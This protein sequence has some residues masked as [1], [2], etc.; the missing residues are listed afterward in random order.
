MIDCCMTRCHTSPIARPAA[1]LALACV[2]AAAGCSPDA[3]SSDRRVIPDDVETQLD[4]QFVR[5]PFKDQAAAAVLRER[6]LHD[7]DF[8]AG[9]TRLTSGGKSR[10]EILTRALRA[11]GGDITVA[12]GAAD[13]KLHQ[14]RIAEV[15]RQLEAA[16]IAPD[17]F[18]VTAQ[19]AGEAAYTA[20]AI[21]I[22]RVIKSKP[23][24]DTRGEILDP[25][26]GASTPSNGGNP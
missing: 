8:Q 17:R 3:P 15:S 18:E 16:G 21:R 19:S 2:L 24:P 6:I 4:R 25:R 26:G 9:S 5:D 23:L 14:A 22:R 20:D 13:P 12:R 11:D 1:A 7:S 10:L